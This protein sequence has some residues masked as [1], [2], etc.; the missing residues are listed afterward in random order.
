[1]Q[2]SCATVASYL[3]CPAG[4][5]SAFNPSRLTMP[6]STYAMAA[7]RI[8]SAAKSSHMIEFL[9]VGMGRRINW[10]PHCCVPTCVCASQ[11]RLEASPVSRRSKSKTTDSGN[12]I[13]MRFASLSSFDNR[14]W[15]PRRLSHLV[16]LHVTLL[17]INGAMPAAESGRRSYR[18]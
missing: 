16:T 4:V 11:S 18:S 12:R 6:I 13:L 7:S 3:P 10:R 17:H 15:A 1:M 9:L 5:D 8:D 14:Q 2:Y